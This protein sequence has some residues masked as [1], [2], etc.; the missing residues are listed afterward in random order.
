MRE[1]E[2]SRREGREILIIIPAYNEAESIG[3]VISSI[4]KASI[5]ADIIVI[6]DGSTDDTGTIARK[7]D[8]IVINHPC[9][10]GIGATMQTGYRFAASQGYG[11][12]VQVDGDGQHPPEQVVRLLGPLME[13]SADVVIGSRFI[14]KGAYKPSL[15]RGIGMVIFSRLISTIMGK[16]FTDTTSGFRAVNKDVISFYADYYP[17][18]YPEVEALILLH[19]AGFRT[20]EVPVTMNVRMG[21]NSSITAFRAVYYMVKVLLAV[22]ID[23]IKKVER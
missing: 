7:S 17:E 11:F 10:L 14:D 16:W 6:N 13:G 5:S 22:Y 12:A 18:D 2:T 20:T 23:L 19:K 8:A 1:R 3:D 9:N 21:G 4:K 15:A